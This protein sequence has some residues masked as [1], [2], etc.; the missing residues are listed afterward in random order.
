MGEYI[1]LLLS[2]DSQI[3]RLINQ[4][5]IY[6]FFDKFMPFITEPK[7]TGIYLLVLILILLLK[8]RMSA[9]K[10]LIGMS[11]AV[12]LADFTAAKILKPEFNR[13]RPE[14]SEPNVKLLVQSQTGGSFPSN[15]AAN[16]FAAAS[17]LRLTSPVLGS[18]ATGIAIIVSYSRVYVGVHYPLDVIGGALLGIIYSSLIY[19]LLMYLFD[20]IGALQ[21]RPTTYSPYNWEK[22]KRIKPKRKIKKKN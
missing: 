7:K 6:P 22:K 15:H 12:G 14:F 1:Q 21:T 3:F 5:W 8:Y 2:Y 20:R 9:V 16:T 18:I 10:V 13:K 4:V 17:F 19:Y 11:I